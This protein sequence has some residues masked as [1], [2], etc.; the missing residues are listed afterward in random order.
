MT[1][2]LCIGLG[3]GLFALGWGLVLL[4]GTLDE[5]GRA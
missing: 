1:D 4:A 2:L 3:L 5:E